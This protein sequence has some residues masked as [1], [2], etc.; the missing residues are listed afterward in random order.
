MSWNRGYTKYTH[1][2]VLKISS[3]MKSRKVDN[4]SKW[5][6]RMRIEGKIIS[7][8]PPLQKNGDLAEL[9]GVVL[10]DGSIHKYARTEGL[11]LTSNATNLGFV[12]RYEKIIFSVFGKKPSVIKRHACEAIDL[13]LYQK[14][15][16]RRLGVHAG[17]RAKSFICVPSWIE[18]DSNLVIRYLRGLYE[19]EG[20]YCVHENT[21]THKFLF[22]NHN[23]S[24]LDNVYKLLIKLGFHPHKSQ[25]QVQLS[26][27][28]EVCRIIEL[29]QFREY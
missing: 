6:K 19:A 23:I 17:A 12:A 10:G 13:R 29:L 22:S 5:R 8:Y 24:M 18:N 7:K 11:R 21:Y 16:S 27:K 4:F 1:P 3:T 28:E 14:H 9:I 25:N 20:S 2:S 15:I 26:K